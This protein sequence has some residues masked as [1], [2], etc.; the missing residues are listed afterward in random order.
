MIGRRHRALNI[1]AFVHRPRFGASCVRVSVLAASLVGLLGGV[2][3]SADSGSSAVATTSGTS[4]APQLLASFPGYFS[5]ENS[6]PD[7]TLAASPT[8][9]MEILNE[10]YAITN[11]T[12]QGTRGTLSQ[13]VGT[14]AV[15]LSDPQVIWDPATAR[16][17]FS[18]FE[19]RGKTKPNEGLAWGFSKTAS[20]TSA[21]DFCKYFARFNYGE[22]AFPDRESLGDTSDFLLIGADRFSTEDESWIGSDLAWITKPPAGATCPTISSLKK[23]IK[24]LK[25]PDGTF[26]FV[27]VPSR[28]ADSS[29]TGWVLATPSSSSHSLTLIR[30]SRTSTGSASIAPP[31]SVPVTEYSAPPYAPQAGQTIGGNPAPPIETRVYLTQ[32]IAAYDPRLAHTALWTA[33]TIAGGAGSE[34]RWYE[35]NPATSSVD[36]VGTVSDPNLFVFNATVA[37]DRSVNEAGGAFGADAVVNVNT[38]SATTDPAIQMV[39]ITGGQPQSGLV[40]VQQSPGPNIDF[41]CFEPV[42]VCRWGDY[43]GAT[44]DP[45]APTSGSTGNVWLANQW[46]VANVNDNTPAW[47]TTVWRATP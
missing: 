12:G 20:P 45:G 38:S 29:P 17:Y 40:H 4:P 47:R 13:L 11:R 8:Q 39:G 32:A 9:V 26:P 22:K 18:V 2:P 7:T 35:I 44:P 42:A 46:N 6:P 34:V 15:F 36:Q 19:N 14:S 25:N 3:A 24:A 1:K 23:G 21:S 37:P 43:S 41:S 28:Q 31:A 33:H 30:V 5:A 10:G 16:F 27:P